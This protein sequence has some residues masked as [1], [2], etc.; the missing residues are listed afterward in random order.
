MAIALRHI[1]ILVALIILLAVSMMP[2]TSAPPSQTSGTGIELARTCGIPTTST[3]GKARIQ[4]V[5]CLGLVH[6]I[7]ALMTYTGHLHYTT[8]ISNGQ[9]VL[10]VKKY[11][12]EHPERLGE[13]DTVLVR[14]ALLAAFPPTEENWKRISNPACQPIL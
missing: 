10:V 13:P 4:Q 7:F 6:G 1:P 9:M 8:F 2:Q 5:Y 14:D 11:L 12:D 3:D